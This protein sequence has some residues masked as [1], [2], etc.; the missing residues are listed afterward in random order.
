MKKVLLI[1]LILISLL[2]KNGVAQGGSCANASPFCTAAGAATF[3]AS[4]NTTAPAGPDYGCL[5]S[6]PNPAWF[7]L[8]IATSGPL[9]LTMSNSAN[10]DID[11]V[12][13]GPFTSS[14]AGCA[15]GLTG[16]PVACSYSSNSTEVGTIASALAGEVYVL[17]ITNYSNQPTTVSLAQTSGT[18]ATNC[19]IVCAMDSLTV[20]PTACISPTNLYNLSGT[21]KYS[22]PPAS[23]TLTVTS[24]S[25][26]SQV[27]NAPFDT[28][29]AN[30]TL[31]GLAADGNPCSVTAVFSHDP[32]CTMVKNFNAPPACYVHCP[33]HVDSAR[34][35]DGVQA[36]LTA[37]GATY[38]LWSTGESAPSITVSGVP[39]S[40]T[41]IGITGTC[42]DT[43][44]A[45]VTTFPP[46][47]VNFTADTLIG[48]NK[49]PVTFTAD[50]T[51]NTGAS[52]SWNFGDGSSGT[53][54]NPLHLYT[55]P[56]CHT[57]LLTESFGQ[58]C[59]TT[60]SVSCMITLF[61]LPLANFTISPSEINIL[62]PTAYFTN[63]SVSATSWLWDFG[64]T[65]SSTIQNPEHTYSY[66]GMYPVTLYASTPNGCIDSVTS[67]VSVKDLVTIYI[68][69]SFTPNKNGINDIFTISS[70]GI[71]PNDFE[72]FIFDRWGKLIFKTNDITEGWNGEANNKGDVL[73]A[74]TY[75][76]HVNYKELTG[77]KHTLFGHISLIK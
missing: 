75:I 5:G 66:V 17:L 15:S 27:F 53:G 46:P 6:E 67:V 30:Y 10:V 21:I 69:N 44:T 43:L 48:C 57:V 70:Y 74:D 60:D 59:S 56:G 50:T 16:S 18:A 49:L 63:S 32:T 25:G 45:L 7:Y 61:A 41:V 20:V 36:T 37:S 9:T 62:A 71:S 35:C 64:D 24:C 40:Y 3:P 22:H 77:K 14:G 68:P 47:T 52:Y 65:T 34:T 29:T 39:A 23:G 8:Q 42:Y 33:I 58:G 19:N 13:W 55:S 26:I 51:G 31:T 38:Y 76:Y 11:F 1:I 28:T 12:C 2:P 72:L 54:S 4:Q 73:L